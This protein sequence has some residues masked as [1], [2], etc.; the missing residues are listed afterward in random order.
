[1]KIHV[2]SASDRNNYG[3]LLFPLVIKKYLAKTN[4]DFSFY[5]YGIIQ[6]DLSGFGALPTES[7][8]DL[9]INLTKD[10]TNKVIIGGG[11]V[12]GGGWLNI[13]RFVNL[14]WNKIYS[15]KYLRYPIVKFEILEKYFFWTT[16]HSRPF[17]LDGL[18]F[19]RNQIFY[20]SIGAQGSL[21]MLRSNSKYQK[22]FNDVKHLSIRDMTSEKIF[23]KFDIKNSL[24]PDSALIMSDLFE[25]DFDDNV[26]SRC[27]KFLE[28]DYIFVQ[29]GD[30]KG[31]KDLERFILEIKEFADKHSFKI[32]LC[33]IGL[34]LDHGD[35]I[36]LKQINNKFPELEYYH[37]ENLYE[38]MFLLKNSKMYVGTSLHGVI[39]AQSFN[40]P[41]FAFPEKITKLK[42]YL[43]TWFEN[44]EEMHGLFSQ[45]GKIEQRFLT[46]NAEV[47]ALNTKKQKDMIYSNFI[48]MFSDNE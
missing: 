29:L 5:N 36:I 6:S 1:M 44:S 3:D 14:F 25:N 2:I 22:Y 35:D 23:N 8:K 41:F 20:N 43:D 39:T 19:D 27:K 7:F 12:I 21:K 45:T 4:K 32:L 13:Q 15:L 10:D 16:G 34:A 42:I 33:P 18:K 28:N 17:I 40:V 31:P 37:P 38:T 24:V 11:E 48:K 30:R 26:S 47:E 46:Y 9:E